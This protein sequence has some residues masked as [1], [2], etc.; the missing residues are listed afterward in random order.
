[1]YACTVHWLHS[2]LTGRLRTCK[3][4]IK[5]QQRILV[6]NSYFL[7]MMG[8]D[9]PPGIIPRRLSHPPI[10][11]PACLSIS[12]LSGTDISSS[13]VQGWLTWPEMLNSLV[14]VFLGR[15]KAANQSPP[16]RQIVGATATVSTLLTVVGQP[17]TPTSAGKGGLSRGLPALPSKDSMREVS[18]PHMYAP[19]PRCK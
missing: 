11:P 1:M 18:S 15:P 4:R 5:V 12:S 8:T 10:T 14:P 6:R 13:T 19:A 7:G 3:L 16:R 9:D 2:K 17:K